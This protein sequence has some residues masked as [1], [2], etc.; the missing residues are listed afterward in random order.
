M[1]DDAI[2]AM[3]YVALVVGCVAAF[4]TGH[5]IIG[6]GLVLLILLG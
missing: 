1:S 3:V 4:Y 2:I 5:Y 6:F